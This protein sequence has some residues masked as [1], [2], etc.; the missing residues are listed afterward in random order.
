MILIESIKMDIRIKRTFAK[1]YEKA[2]KNIRWAFDQRIVIFRQDPFHPFLHN[3]ALTGVYKGYR[4]INI[5][6]DWRALYKEV[7]LDDNKVIIEFHLLGT[8]SQ[9]YK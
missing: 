3:H 7:L 5:T 1:Q 8:H 6:G 9:L 2:P 4:S